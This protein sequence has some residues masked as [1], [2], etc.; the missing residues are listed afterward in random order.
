MNGWVKDNNQYYYFDLKSY[1][2]HTGWL[3]LGEKTYYLVESG[4]RK[5]QRITGWIKKG[6]NYYCFT[7]KGVMYKSCKKGQYEFDE[8][9][10]CI[11]R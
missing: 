4:S 3:T 9:G 11:N 1:K 2:M 6:N 8:N 7:S 5:G 10:V